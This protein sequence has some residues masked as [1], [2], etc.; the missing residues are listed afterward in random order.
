MD[1]QSRTFDRACGVPALLEGVQTRGPR[2]RKQL[3]AQCGELLSVLIRGD[4]EDG[5]GGTSVAA[6]T[7]DHLPCPS[8]NGLIS[9]PIYQQLHAAIPW[10]G[11]GMLSRWQ[12]CM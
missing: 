11:V 4:S 2:V 8:V 3:P 9:T 5:V 12:S 10:C 7:S 6:D 1:H